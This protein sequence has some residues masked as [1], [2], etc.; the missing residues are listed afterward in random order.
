MTFVFCDLATLPQLETIFCKDGIRN[1]YSLTRERLAAN[2]PS[3][4]VEASAM[5]GA[6]HPRLNGSTVLAP[7]GSSERLSVGRATT[8][9]F[10][11][12]M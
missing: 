4:P 7:V 5:G 3:V 1:M 11:L 10:S 2:R 12:V 9:A 6:D 8:S